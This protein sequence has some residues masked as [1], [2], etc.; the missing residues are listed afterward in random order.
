MSFM[1]LAFIMIISAC[2]DSNSVTIP[3]E[4]DFSGKSVVVVMTIE[5][6]AVNRFH[7]KETFGTIANQI[8]EIVDLTYCDDP[9]CVCNEG[10]TQI[11]CLTLSKDD[12]ANVL[13]VVKYLNTLDVVD[14]A[15]P[16]YILTPTKRVSK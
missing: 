10:I 11:L 15:E 1:M 6:N 7:D 13:R 12:K 9:E 8:V 2:N 3:I 5:A 4:D 16:L 14:Y